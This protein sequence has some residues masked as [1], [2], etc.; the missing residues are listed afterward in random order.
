MCH[1]EMLNCI[2]SSIVDSGNHH[3][4]RCLLLGRSFLLCAA[5]IFKFLSQNCLASITPVNAV[6]SVILR[7]KYGWFLVLF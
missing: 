6:A 1:V 7:S 4:V 2:L 3:I 5:L